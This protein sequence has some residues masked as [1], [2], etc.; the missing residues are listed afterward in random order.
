MTNGTPGL[1]VG[2]F[3]EPDGTQPMSPAELRMV[4]EAVGLTQ[5]DLAVWL[6]VADRTVRRWEAGTSHV[7]DGVRE[8]LEARER[9][10]VEHAD[11]IAGQLRDAADAVLSVPRDGEPPET[12]AYWRAV[13]YRVAESLPGLY[14]RY[15]E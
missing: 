6:G 1:R 5:E 12:A 7:P 9:A 8:A 10:L 15:D 13:A 11:K 2:G 3:P 4:R 14:V